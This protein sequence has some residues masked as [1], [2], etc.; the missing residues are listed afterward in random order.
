MLKSVG[1][2]VTTLR[3]LNSTFASKFLVNDSKYLFLKELGLK[4]NNNG[5]YDGQWGG[6]GKVGTRFSIHYYVI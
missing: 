6:D 2:R 3:R 5:V 4:E 1:S